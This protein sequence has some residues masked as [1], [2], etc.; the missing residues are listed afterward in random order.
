MKIFIRKCLKGEEKLWVVFWLLT[1]IG[2][3]ILSITFM[4]VLVHLILNPIT[5]ITFN[6][7]SF[8][9]FFKYL[10]ALILGAAFFIFG[11]WFELFTMISLWK[12]SWNS[13][14]RIWGYLARGFLV[15]SIIFGVIEEVIN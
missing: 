3:L 11:I 7:P 12:C 6:N 14:K 2:N 5:E 15:T 13:K 1:I 4:Y 9:T 8:T 10:P